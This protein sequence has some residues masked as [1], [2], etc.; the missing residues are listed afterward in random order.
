M[1]WALILEPIQAPVPNL[2]IGGERLL[3][4]PAYA[5]LKMKRGRHPSGA[6]R[7]HR[8]N[9]LEKYGEGGFNV[10]LEASMIHDPQNGPLHE[11]ATALSARVTVRFGPSTFRSSAMALHTPIINKHVQFRSSTPVIASPEESSAAEQPGQVELVDH[12]GAGGGA[13][14][15]DPG[16]GDFFSDSVFRFRNRGRL[17]EEKIFVGV[18]IVVREAGDS[19][20]ST[21]GSQ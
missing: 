18:E 7:E 4:D 15:Q 3:Q 9:A 16:A 2:G 10:R 8:Q 21:A 14:T 5:E 20:D 11:D 12:P 1:I 6:L 19:S 17:L 13:G